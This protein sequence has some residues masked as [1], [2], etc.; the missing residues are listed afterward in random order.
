[1][2]KNYLLTGLLILAFVWSG[3]AQNE[4][5]LLNSGWKAK[6]S[7]ELT[8]DG[9]EISSQDFELFDWMEAVVPG[10]VLTTMLHNNKVPD[11]FYG[12]N[13]ELIPDIHNTGA[14]YYTFWFHNRFPLPDLKPGQQVWLKFRG[15]NYTANVFLNGNRV[16]T[17]THEGMFLREKYLI[18]P[19]LNG[20]SGGINNLAVIVHPPDP[21]GDANGGQG[22][23]GTIAR[24][25]TQQYTA[26]WDWICPIR[27]RN[28][29]IW[30]QVSIE[31]AGPVDV[32]NSFVQPKV[33]G[34]R[35]PAEKQKPAYLTISTE[36]VNA[37]EKQQGGIVVARI[38]DE[39]W[40]LPSTIQAGETVTVTFPEIKIENPKLWWPNGLGEQNQYKLELS[41]E[42]N[43]LSS[44]KETVSFGIRETDTYFDKEVGGR[45]FLVNG[46][47][48]FIKGGNWIASDA[49]LRL[50]PE[51]YEA[52]VR[53]HAEMNMNMIRVWGGA[54]PERPEFYDA[55]DK[56]GLLVW[57]DFWVSGDCNG[58]WPDPRKK[59][60]QA[61]RQA[62]PD[63]HSLF[64][65]S[66]IDQIK[67]LRNHPS[68]YMW[69]GGNEFPPP[70][71]IN[72][73]L[74]ETIF[75]KYDGTRFY[76]NESTSAS[77]LRN[78]IGGNGD[79]PY[80]IQNPLRFFVTQSYPF[81]P[82]LGSVGMPNVETMRKMM[83][84]KDLGPPR[85]DRPSLVWRYHKYIGYGNYIE[86]M[87]EIAGIDD[88][89]KKAQ[90]VNYEQY[91][92]LQEGFNAGMWDKY[93]GML[94]WKNQNPWTALRGQFYDVFLDQNGGFYGYKHGAKPLH[95]QLNLNDSM[96][97]I[98]NQTFIDADNLVVEAELIDLK[99]NIV[100]QNQFSIKNI[101]ANSYKNAGYLFK[102][103]KPKGFYFV[104]L[105]LK[106]GKNEII[107]ENLY[108]L[109]NED[110]DWQ[111][112]QKLAPVKLQVKLQKS[113][114]KEYKVD[115]RNATNSVAFF[116]RLKIIGNESGELALPVFFDDNYITLFPGE[117]KQIDID[118]SHLPKGI[119]TDSLLL[120][121]AP[122]NGESVKQN[123]NKN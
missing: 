103:V 34:K 9:T 116:T 43:N 25:V 79:G 19:F 66:A 27:D 87:G 1:M 93:T 49:M 71:D 22:G 50:L 114:D 118:L 58:R 81:N 84:K 64:I 32:Q 52:E 88:F 61:R 111:E 3:F 63:N 67:M 56:Y 108:W 14:G 51:R 74:E 45:V 37:T 97:Y 2:C 48:V 26:G 117:Q 60:S 36:L 101:E 90:V 120:E 7:N 94:V 95:V 13:N 110:A 91:R 33:P 54:M 82:E 76:V 100:G 20:E 92:A 77:I 112:L 31:I 86:R 47:K 38:G 6:R 85:N 105:I 59:E 83:D 113:E 73:Q 68:L 4:E 78:T 12:M 16:N 10:T 62:Y 96:V 40:T 42:Q 39:K 98:Q 104:R 107:D 69:C 55:C 119:T 99:G 41:F 44:D 5:I 75:P 65:T 23:D 29:G 121:L 46:Q 8:V 24:S 21:V 123:F 109:T 70:A 72:K 102:N 28:T 15:I 80:G 35:I 11:P 17:D 30:D 57:Q 115:I 18:T 53:M 89:C 106:N 122:W